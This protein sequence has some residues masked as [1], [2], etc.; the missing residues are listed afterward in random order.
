MQQFSDWLWGQTKKPVVDHTGLAGVYD[1]YLVHGRES[2]AGRTPADN[3]ASE[4]GG[5][6][7]IHAVQALGLKLEPQKGDVETLVIEHVNR[8]PTAN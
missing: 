4:P 8:V 3:A 1:F 2:L 7:I 5:P 6:D